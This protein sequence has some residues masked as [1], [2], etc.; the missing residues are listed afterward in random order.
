MASGRKRSRGIQVSQLAV[1]FNPV[2]IGD[3][4]VRTGHGRLWQ[5]LLQKSVAAGRE[6]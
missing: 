6:A 4:K 3:A 1:V 5:I 2:V